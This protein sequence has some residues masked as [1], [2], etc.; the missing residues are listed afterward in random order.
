VFPMPQALLTFADCETSLRKLADVNGDGQEDLISFTASGV[1]VQLLTNSGLTSPEI[2]TRAYTSETGGWDI[3]NRHPVIL[4]DINGDGMADI[5][6]FGG[7]QVLVALST[8]SRFLPLEAWVNGYGY[9]L[10][11]GNWKIDRHPRVLAD[12]N[13]DG[14]R[15]IV[16]FKENGVHVSLSISNGFMEPQKWLSNYGYDHGWFTDK[17]PRLLGDV[18][19]NGRDDIVAFG[20]NGAYVSLSTGS[21]FLEPQLWIDEFG[22]EAGKWRV[23]SHRRYLR[24]VNGDGKLDI[25]GKR[26]N[27]IYV[28]LS[29]GSRFSPPLV[30][31]NLDN[32]VWCIFD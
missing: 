28:S 18:N 29:D 5:V 12:V 2:W 8:G 24:D 11:G 17:H 23:D 30:D 16:G 1:A 32:T 7:N 14:V 6:G 15:D 21:S 31:L 26:D 27:T 9:N 19:G 25:V 13:G 22:Y 3:V 10:N 20:D 4:A